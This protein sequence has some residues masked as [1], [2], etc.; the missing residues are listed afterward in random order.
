VELDR[1]P[2]STPLSIDE[3][4]WLH[5]KYERLAEEEGNLAAT[6]TSYFAAIA[7]VLVTGLVVAT[8]DLVGN[9]DLLVLFATFFAGF[10]ALIAA[11]WA[12]LF[13][14]TT[15]AQN[16]WRE[17]A[18]RLEDLEPPIEG[19]LPAPITL[20]SGRT[21]SVDLTRPYQAHRARFDPKNHISLLDR[22]NPARLSEIM[23]LTLLGIWVATV[24]VVWAWFLFLR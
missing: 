7:A 2:G 9:A 8:S 18:L 13:H 17:A 14:R 5:D 22:V 21:I 1:S 4:R 19:S 16:L 12:V 11:V 20:R 3:R 10:G 24:V 15:D 6:R 23:P